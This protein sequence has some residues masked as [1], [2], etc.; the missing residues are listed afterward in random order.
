MKID[1]GY[2]LLS[3]KL[4]NS[5]VMKMPPATREIWLYI[6]RK[7]NHAPY[8]NLKR[9]ENIFSYKDIQDDLCWYVGYRKEKYSKSDIAKSLRRLRESNMIETTKATR[10]LIIKVL[11]YSVY[12]DPKNYEGNYE[13]D[14]KETRR[15]RSA[16]T[17][18][19]KKKNVKNNNIYISKFEI[20]WE[21]YPRKIGKQKVEKI[22]KR[23]AT[24]LKKETEIMEGLKKYLRKWRL[25]ETDKQFIPYPS[26][27]LNQERW[28]DEVEMSRD[29]YNK[30]ARN[31]E[32]KWRETKHKEKL[33]Y[34]NLRKE[35]NEWDF[36]K[37]SKEDEK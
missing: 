4:D 7:V 30:F 14:T 10:G 2:I 24:S 28:K 19:K 33:I 20:F 23:K 5:E 32:D 13:R 29:V 26:S 12:Q 25:E 6:L 8:K 1:G 21:K 35:D 18:Y 15:K 16:S 36:E 17:I 3:R 37:L 34:S 9:G 11:Q 27:W 31:S 22:Y